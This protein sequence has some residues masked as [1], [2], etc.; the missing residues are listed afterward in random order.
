MIRIGDRVRI[1]PETL[2]DKADR[3]LYGNEAGVVVDFSEHAKHFP[4]L[5]WLRSFGQARW[6]KEENLE[7]VADVLIE[8]KPGGAVIIKAG[9][10]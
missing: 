4:W 9:D 10:D 5:V 1:K 2:K 8:H 7:P 6:F 3:D